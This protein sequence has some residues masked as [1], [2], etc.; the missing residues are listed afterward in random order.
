MTDIQDLLAKR[1]PTGDD[2]GLTAEE[3]SH[4]VSTPSLSSQLS[5]GCYT[6]SQSGYNSSNEQYQD[7]ST[8]SD[9]DTLN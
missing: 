7:T 1:P 5:S 2:T 3:A 8:S 9:D 6:T 4:S